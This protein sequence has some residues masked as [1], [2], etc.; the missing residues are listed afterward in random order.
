MKFVT[1]YCSKLLQCSL[2]YSAVCVTIVTVSILQCSECCLLGNCPWK[3]LEENGLKSVG[4]WVIVSFVCSFPL[5]T[6]RVS[7]ELVWN[8]PYR[9]IYVTVT[10]NRDLSR[11]LSWTT[12]NFHYILSVHIVVLD[13][14]SLIGCF[15]NSQT[16]LI[17]NQWHELVIN[18]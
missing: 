7:W 11:D 4:P 6:P 2:E 10:Q 17:D 1:V 18:E 14:Q 16:Y 15:E 8:I 3:V 9:E 13:M 12:C 5:G